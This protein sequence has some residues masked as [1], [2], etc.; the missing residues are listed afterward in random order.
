MKQ[1]GTRL[2]SRITLKGVRFINS[3]LSLRCQVAVFDCDGTLWTGDSG[4]GFFY[5]E[6]ENGVISQE[7]AAWARSRY[8]DYKAGQVDEDTMCGE[9]VTMH[10][11]LAEAE[12]ERQA[13]KYFEQHV[14]PQIFPE[15][16]ELI[17][18]LRKSG[19]DVWVVSSTNEWVIRAGMKYFGVPDDRVLAAAVEVENGTITD[20]LLRVPSGGGKPKAIKE[21][22]ERA[23]DAAFGNS[24]WDTEMLSMARY[25][26]VVNPFPE[27]ERSA[28]EHH[29]PIYW[30]D[31]TALRPK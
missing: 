11:G 17:K 27:L 19:C 18:R 7:V 13:A 16:K 5:W 31:G 4:E 20:R 10:R 30:P 24:R 12:L 21:A 14:V 3:V 25:P 15:M 26:F 23:P 28:E 1:E 2:N 29:W 22:V 6:I 9:M 8:A